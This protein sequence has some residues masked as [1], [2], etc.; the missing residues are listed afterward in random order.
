MELATST[1][2]AGSPVVIMHGL[3]GSARNWRSIAKSLSAD[4]EVST[5]DLRNHGGSPWTESM[6]YESMAADVI[7][8]LDRRGY[9][10]VSIIGHSMGGKTAMV[11]ARSRPDL[12]ERL[13]VVDIAPASSLSAN[14]LITQA[15]MSVDL[16]GIQ[17]RAEVDAWLADEIREPKMRGFLLQN[18]VPGEDGF[19]WRVNLPV[20]YQSMPALRGFPENLPY[21][22][23]DGPTLV[24]SG[25]ESDYVRDDHHGIFG[26]MFSNLEMIV[27]KGAGHD[28][29]ADRPAAFLDAV[30]PFL[31]S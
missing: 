24:I 25:E 15:L 30:R 18:L 29:H 7:A 8:L 20:I 5:V 21:A 13:V 10:K 23:F 31:R 28:V 12:V 17:S 19:S 6:D 11:L 3:F 22:R 26:E 16:E 4:H 1:F 2:G 9:K 14:L 27:I